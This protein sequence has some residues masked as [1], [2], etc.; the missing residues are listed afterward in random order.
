MYG[1]F[2]LSLKAEKEMFRKISLL[3]ISLQ[4]SCL[5]FAQ[6]NVKDFFKE[7]D[8]LKEYKG[9]LTVY[10]HG[11][12]FYWEIP[13]S[14]LDRN[15]YIFKTILSA[16]EQPN[17]GANEKYGYAGDM[18][19]PMLFSI[20]KKG[21]ELWIMDTAHHDRIISGSSDYS[22]LALTSE[23][24]RMYTRLEVKAR[25]DKSSLVDITELIK[26]NGLFTL[27]PA[28]FHLKVGMN[29]PKHYSV[30][31]IQS[32]RDRLLM[33]IT[34]GHE[35]STMSINFAEPSASYKGVWETGLCIGLLEKEPIDLVPA[36]SGAYFSIYKNVIEEDNSIKKKHFI[37]RWRLEVKPEDKEKY[38][39]GELV[40]P[41]KPITFYIDR[42][43]PHK[44]VKCVIDA[45]KDWSPAFEQAG[46]KNAIDARLAPTKEENPDFRTYDATYPFI[47]WKISP[48]ANAYGPSPCESRSGEII[49]CH[50]GIFS[51]V[52][53]ILQNWYFVQ[54]GATDPSACQ[55][56][57]PD[58]VQSELIKLVLTH[59]VGH[60]LGLEHNFMASSHFSI[61]QLRDNE[62]LTKNGITSSIM[63]YV[64][65]NYALRPE[66]RVELRNRRA[67]LGEYDRW[68]IEW[69][70]R[71]FEGNTV[72][73]RNK[74]REKWSKESLKNPLVQFSS[75]LEVNSK[76][77]DLG[78]D[79]ITLNSQGIENIK[80]L[81]SKDDIW[82]VKDVLSRTI[83]SGR[84]KTMISHYKQW[85][86]H[87][88][89]HLGGKYKSTEGVE[90]I[91][92]PEKAEYNRRVVRF[93]NDY[94]VNPPEYLFDKK[95]I[96]LGVDVDK[97][98]NIFYEA[99][100]SELFAAV[101]RSD[102]HQQSSKD[103]ITVKE[104]LG[105]ITKEMFSEWNS[106][107][108]TNPHK[109]IIQHL[110]IDKLLDICA[111]REN[112]SSSSLLSVALSNL[113]EIKNKALTVC[114]KS[115]DSLE[116]NHIQSVIS[117]IRF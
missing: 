105:E 93:V 110:Y 30:S 80:Y 113:V 103:M 3:I 14:I 82:Q 28:S 50:I 51:G 41:V 66:D 8:P 18:V 15:M 31:D 57:I 4:V 65:F 58:S 49:G 99:L 19:G 29:I 7:K 87:V 45:I 37:K 39:R 59:E 88:L 40:E 92:I 44:Y 10:E 78:N 16:P 71:V 94:L 34:R 53:N 36:F 6:T 91:Y 76:W 104:I 112:T 11:E 111:F 38:M 23:T 115:K 70:Y 60:T 85:V 83:L 101:K 64:R 98:F 77:E 114:N 54:C 5:S 81:C 62:F 69:G 86:E 75:G 56:I 116:V 20:S 22:R 48:Q 100:M 117:R 33:K 61:N 13:D 63:D 68:A 97:E 79:H 84:Y 24:K 67:R 1:L 35:S 73:E 107:I 102:L 27:A 43:T 47:S 108:V 106:N 90:A 42:N 17:R 74:N 32:Y 72:E 52:M 2:I 25:G 89:L 9:M 55:L 96:A 109:R 26:N 95:F 21:N 46:F 12:K